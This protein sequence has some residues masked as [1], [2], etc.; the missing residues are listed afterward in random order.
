MQ[1]DIVAKRNQQYTDDPPAYQPPP[2]QWHSAPPPMYSPP[3]GGYYGWM[4]PTD[5]FPNAPPGK[6]YFVI[7][8]LAILWILRLTFVNL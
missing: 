5:A 8:I 1:F 2:G 7:V 3:N 4:P 6:F